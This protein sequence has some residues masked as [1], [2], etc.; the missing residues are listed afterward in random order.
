MPL[1]TDTLT[2]LQAEQR[3][4]S[5]Q[6]A[7]ELSTNV[8]E[9]EDGLNNL[10]S[11]PIFTAEFHEEGEGDEEGTAIRLENQ[12][13]FVAVGQDSDIFLAPLAAQVRTNTILALVIAALVAFAAILVAQTIANPV[14]RLTSVAQQIAGGDINIQAKVDLRDEIGNLAIS[15]NTMTAQ[16]RDLIGSLEQRV[17]DRTKA[18]ATSMKLAAVYL[19]SWT[20]NNWSWK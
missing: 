8:Q 15:F 7:E 20:K 4:P 13:W 17:T 11:E 5:G 10:D 9:L 18:L 14:S 6:S 12:P 16:L 19:R 1:P 3:L 2:Q